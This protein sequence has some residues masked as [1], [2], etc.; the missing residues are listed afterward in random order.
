[1]R[2]G[3]HKTNTM[4]DMPCILLCVTAYHKGSEQRQ[5]HLPTGIHGCQEVT[6]DSP[7]ERLGRQFWMAVCSV[8][9]RTLSSSERSRWQPKMFHG[10][11]TGS[12]SH[13]VIAS[14]A[15]WKDFR[16]V[17]CFHGRVLVFFLGCREEHTMR[18]QPAHFGEKCLHLGRDAHYQDG[19]RKVCLAKHFTWLAI[20]VNEIVMELS[21]R[22]THLIPV[23]S[24][25]AGMLIV[26]KN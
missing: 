18:Q 17:L 6:L 12:V 15:S 26:S 14:A 16:W 21:Q 13:L 22:L 24:R 2:F 9:R 19:Q 20:T 1:M 8:N 11:P 5:N 10:G 23:I 4:Y 7:I 25:K 3:T